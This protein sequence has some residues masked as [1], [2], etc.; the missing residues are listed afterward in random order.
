MADPSSY[1]LIIETDV[2]QSRTLASAFREAGYGAKEEA[3]P[4]Q[5]VRRAMEQEPRVI[6]MSEEMTS[7]EG[8]DLLPLMQRVT[9]VPMV[10]LGSRGQTSAANALLNGA[11]MYVSKPVT[12]AEILA[13]VGA[14]LRRSESAQDSRL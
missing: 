12:G 4:G 2:Q 7:L 8:V 1:V 6:L 13:R 10:V 5:A 14:L 11:D 3:Q 9:S